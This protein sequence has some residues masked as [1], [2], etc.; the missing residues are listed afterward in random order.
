MAPRSR[1]PLY[2]PKVLK[3]NISNKKDFAMTVT[4]DDSEPPADETRAIL[5]ALRRILRAAD[6]HSR[7]LARLTGLT[8]PQLVV[9]QAIAEL[10]EVTTGRISANANLSQATVT[11]ILDKLV[12]RGL[13]ERYR[14]P[15]DRR[16]VHSRLTDTGREALAT[17]APLR[18]ERLVRAYAHL[19]QE[20]RAEVAAALGWVAETLETYA[21]D[22]GEAAH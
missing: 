22:L 15:A 9:L 13:V 19:P 14:S 21:A 3:S 5:T 7:E 18:N 1:P 16:V 8:M 17:A 6:L 4:F 10:G 20:R 2:N 11:V 12:A